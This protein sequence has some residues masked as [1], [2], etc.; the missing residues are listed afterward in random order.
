MSFGPPSNV[1]PISS[2]TLPAGCW[3]A[4]CLCIGGSRCPGLGALVCACPLLVAA[5]Q[6]LGTLGLLGLCLGGAVSQVSG[7][8]LLRHRRLLAGPG[9]PVLWGAFGCQ[10]LRS[11]P[12]VSRVQGGRSVSPHTGYCIL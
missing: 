1:G 11:P 10:W 8:D 2:A 3:P 6:G 9:V 4:A 7:L 5:C 12:C